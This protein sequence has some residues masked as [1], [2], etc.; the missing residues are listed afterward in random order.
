MKTFGETFIEAIENSMERVN[1]NLTP[2]DWNLSLCKGYEYTSNVGGENSCML[3]VCK[4]LYTM[5]MI[6]LVWGIHEYSMVLYKKNQVYVKFLGVNY[7]N[8]E[9][10]NIFSILHEFFTV[11]CETS[12]DGSPL[13]D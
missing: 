10:D 2:A 7:M 12:G 13:P 9:E 6:E 11:L 3:H 4:D 1:E 5:G 8:K